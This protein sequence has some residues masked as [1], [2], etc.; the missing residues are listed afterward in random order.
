[1]CIRDSPR[2]YSAVN[3]LSDL[4][5]AILSDLAGT[6]EIDVFRRNLQKFYVERLISMIIS[7]AGASPSIAVFGTVIPGRI[8]SKKSDV[9]SLIKS[10]LK[11]L[12]PILVSAS[13]RRSESISKM[14]LD[15]L[16]DRIKNA[17]EPK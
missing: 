8:D 3:Y 14:H 16:A 2:A 10:N 11:S 12:R 15:D 17:L 7:P 9:L 5:N 13:N 1:M 4:Q 6:K